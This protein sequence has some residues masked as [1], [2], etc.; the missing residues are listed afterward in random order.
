MMSKTALLAFALAILSVAPVARAEEP[1]DVR[2]AYTGP[3]TSPYWPRFWEPW[4]KKVEQD[5]GGSL[6]I[7]GYLGTR[8][9]TMQNVYDR[10]LSGAFEIGYGIHSAYGGKF[11]RTS[12]AA[13]PFITGSAK[14][15]STALHKLSDR[16]LLA[17]E[18]KDVV[19]LAEYTYPGIEL[20]SSKPVRT[21]EDMKGLKV[22]A[23]DRSSAQVIEKLGGVPVTM[24]PPDLYQAASRGTVQAITIAYTGVLQFKVHEVTNF[25][26]NGLGLGAGS[27]FLFANKQ[28][29]EGLPAQARDA[30]KKNS[31]WETS[32]DFGA[33]IDS[34]IT[35]QFEAVSKMPGQTMETIAPQERERW[36][37]TSQSIIDDWV[38]STPNGAAIL[39]AYKE[40]QEKAK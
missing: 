30:I 26:L 4:T 34:V 35:E 22:A 25:H 13:L 1:I 39:A 15:S 7:E 18:N 23:I 20:H 36:V 31:T 6:K 19:V 33:V 40:E 11:P 37:K 21:I 12:V 32:R 8:L 24:D 3:P 38:K 10:L 17:D 9:A 28:W 29:F 14:A 16:G 27:G 2:F 5:S